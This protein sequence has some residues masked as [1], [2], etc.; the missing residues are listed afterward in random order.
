MG[1][2]NVTKPSVEK[3]SEKGRDQGLRIPRKEAYFRYAAV[4]RDEAERRDRFFFGAVMGGCFDVPAAVVAAMGMGAS[5]APGECFRAGSRFS[6]LRCA[7][8][9]EGR[10]RA[11]R[12]RRWA[13]WTRD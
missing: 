4:T 12:R 3:A 5:T 1:D 10:H 2:N 13:P 8:I 6:P 11:A 9:G 7:S